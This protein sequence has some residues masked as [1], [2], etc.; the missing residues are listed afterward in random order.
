MDDAP[1]T[2]AIE[3]EEEKEEIGEV[4]EVTS[5]EPPLPASMDWSDEVIEENNT[6]DLEDQNQ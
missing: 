1:R 4:A 6:L 5:S 2:T 3:E